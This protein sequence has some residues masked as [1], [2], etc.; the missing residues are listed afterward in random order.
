MIADRSCNSMTLSADPISRPLKVVLF[1]SE[2]WRDLHVEETS[3]L[4]ADFGY[5]LAESDLT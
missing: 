1:R 3:V 5:A 2:S 4:E